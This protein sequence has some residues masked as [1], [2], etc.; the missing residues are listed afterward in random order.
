MEKKPTMEKCEVWYR[1][2]GNKYVID[3]AI[4][5]TF[6]TKEDKKILI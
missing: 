5:G 6:V 2:E 1:K 3:C 4:K